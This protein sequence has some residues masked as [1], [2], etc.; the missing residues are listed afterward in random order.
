MPNHSTGVVAGLV[1][2]IHVFLRCNAVQ[3]VGAA[4][5]AGMTARSAARPWQ[6]SPCGKPMPETYRRSEMNDDRGGTGAA[7]P[8]CLLRRIGCR[9]PPPIWRD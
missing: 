2:A 4:T 3:G 9:L 7:Q 8:R 1:P 6:K 5:S